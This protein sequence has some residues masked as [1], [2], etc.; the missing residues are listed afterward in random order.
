[1][2]IT[3]WMASGCH[4]LLDDILE[5][6][7]TYISWLWYKGQVGNIGKALGVFNLYKLIQYTVSRNTFIRSI[8]MK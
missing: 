1:M 5:K 2:Y 7:A 3:L 8:W 6:G 4:T